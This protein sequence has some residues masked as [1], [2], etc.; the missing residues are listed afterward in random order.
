MCTYLSEPRD[1]SV[2]ALAS[3]SQLFHF[4][5]GPS[6]C[7]EKAWLVCPAPAGPHAMLSTWPQLIPEGKV[8]RQHKL[9]DRSRKGCVMG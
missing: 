2:P 4:T 7:K 3:H 8:S 6:S 9:T 5:Q 1:T